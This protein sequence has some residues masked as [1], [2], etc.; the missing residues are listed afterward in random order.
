MK[1]STSL[2][3]KETVKLKQDRRQAKRRINQMTKTLSEVL[4][5]KE[6]NIPR[7][8][9]SSDDTPLAKLRRLYDLFDELGEHV[10]DFTSCGA[11]C[12]DCCRMPVSVS[13]LEIEYIE[14]ETGIKRSLSPIA[15][16]GIGDCPFL[17]EHRCSIYHARP[18]LCRRHAVYSGDNY[19]CDPDRCNEVELGM[20]GFSGMDAAMGYL[21]TT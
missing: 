2:T 11:G 18:F 10:A 15:R 12:A 17:K 5:D 13:E 19:W 9:M 4:A 8:L 20:V 3:K 1:P 21:R 6:E 16:E 14:T 7:E